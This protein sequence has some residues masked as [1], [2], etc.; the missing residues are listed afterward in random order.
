MAYK[1]NIDAA[2]RLDIIEAIEWYNDK[3]RGLG[4]RFYEH[5][6]TALKNI[7]KNPLGYVIR[8]K[9]I[10]TAI[11]NKFPYMI[12]YVVDQGVGINR[13]SPE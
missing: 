5:I 11:I 2:A 7:Q 8:Y 1:I 3:Q 13:I 9:T 12:L 4:F 10:H 6:K